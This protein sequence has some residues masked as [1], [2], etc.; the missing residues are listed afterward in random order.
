MD[1]TGQ[2]LV[3]RKQ[4]KLKS[5]HENL[6]NERTQERPHRNAYLLRKLEK[7]PIKFTKIGRPTAF[8]QIEK[9]DQFLVTDI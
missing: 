5:G 8:K 7:F 4:V 2:H 6:Q 9:F 1:V 3:R